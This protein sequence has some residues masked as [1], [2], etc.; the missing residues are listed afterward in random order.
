MK[1]VLA[2]WDLIN[3]FILL[4]EGIVIGI[5][6]CIAYD[7][8]REIKGWFGE[9]V[10][11][12]LL[13]RH[14]KRHDYKI[15]NNIYLHQS[16]GY[17]HQIDHIV[18]S[19]WGIFV[20]ETKTFDG[21]LV[22][23]NNEARRWTY[24]TSSNGY[25]YWQNPIKQNRWHIRALADCL[26]HPLEHFYTIVAFAGPI[27]FPSKIP[28]NVVHFDDV[29]QYIQSHSQTTIILPEIVQGLVAQIKAL[30]KAVT[31]EQRKNHNKQCQERRKQKQATI[32]DTPPQ[33]KASQVSTPQSSASVSTH[34]CQVSTNSVQ[35]YTNFVPTTT[36]P[37]LS[38]KSEP[39]TYYLKGLGQRLVHELD[40]NHYRVLS[41]GLQLLGDKEN[42]S[43]WLV[44]SPWGIFVVTHLF[45]NGRINVKPE[46]H[47]WH[48]EYNVK[49]NFPNPLEQNN[50]RILEWSRRLQIPV[51]DF[52]S[53]IAFNDKAVFKQKTPK[54]VLHCPQVSEY[55]RQHSQ[56][57]VFSQ[58]QIETLANMV[59]SSKTS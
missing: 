20:I 51:E 23:C 2:V 59:S 13:R 38:A 1:I 8:W 36:A 10:L 44:L 56:T 33:P 39:T 9:K 25:Y 31:K 26:G 15:L 18:V 41:D 32:K 14:L 43:H 45:Y 22:Q 19:Q 50:D 5:L 58:S 30:D 49:Y 55:L 40:I 37:V 17:T 42:T 16:N 47:I 12:I 21:E 35:S 7:K 29:A 27:K 53:V 24:V 52:H 3:P 28:A 6:F 54:N 11:W 48:A 46:S 57:T 4:L 34:N